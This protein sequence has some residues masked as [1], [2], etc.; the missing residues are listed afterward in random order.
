M[1]DIDRLFKVLYHLHREPRDFLVAQDALAAIRGCMQQIEDVDH[2]II[3]LENQ[4][5]KL[6]P[7]CVDAISEYQ[8]C[9]EKM[10]YVKSRKSFLLDLMT[11]LRIEAG[12]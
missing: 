9:I 5:D 1:F 11:P 8:E 4:R 7:N 3:E 10:Q 12:M 6:D 2:A